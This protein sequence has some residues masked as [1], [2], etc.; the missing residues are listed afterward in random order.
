MTHYA[1]S[2]A[3]SRQRLL[4]AVLDLNDAQ[5]SWRI[6]S[7]ALSIGQMAVHVAGVEVSFSSQ[8]T[9]RELSSEEKKIKASATDG[10]VNEKPFPYEDSEL[11][12]AKVSEILETGKRWLEP[13]ITDPTPE[14]LSKELVSALGPVITGDGALTR[15]AFHSA[16]HEGQAYLIRTAPGFP[17]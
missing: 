9:G 2:W 14:L 17:G 15:L 3:L 1:N 12:P 10:V 13:V 16:Y 8:L 7:K 6:H 4:N 5:L 11:T